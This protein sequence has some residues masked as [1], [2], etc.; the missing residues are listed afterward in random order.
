MGYR[1]SYEP[2]SQGQVVGTIL[3]AKINNR[4]STAEYQQQR[5]SAERSQQREKS[6]ERSQQR[7]VTERSQERVDKRERRYSAVLN[8][9]QNKE[10]SNQ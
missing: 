1:R 6:T 3:A 10:G 2:Y 7:G 5:V 4:V 8:R 9:T